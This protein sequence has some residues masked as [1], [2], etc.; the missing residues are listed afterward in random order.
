MGRFNKHV[1]IVG[2][3]RSG[4]SWLSET[5]ARQHRYR[6]L[7][8]PEQETRTRRGYL[9]CDQWI[10]NLED[11]PDAHRYLKQVFANGVNC[12]WIAQNSNRRFK[13]HL[14]PLIPKKYIIK[15]VRANLLAA[16]MN[17]TFNIPVIHMVRNPYAVIQ[18]QLQV[19]FPWLTDMRHFSSQPKLVQL[20][21][22][23]I[24]LDITALSNF[25]KVELLALRW[26]IENV[27]P[28]EV[29]PHTKGQYEVVRYEDLF[30]DIDYFYS[31]CDRVH[32]KPIATIEED[33]SLPSSK[34]HS[35][36]TFLGKKTSLSYT[37][38]EDLEAIQA[39]LNTFRTQLYPTIYSKVPYL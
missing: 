37:N 25:S 36:S 33:Y 16:Y 7:F 29:L 15:F 34:T 28:L 8:E 14:W 39:I 18:S 1:I 22:D 6:M 38:T 19:D 17:T 27:I 9:L 21:Q 12:D 10:R 26:C 31:L 35:K 23:H 24:S 30:T 13:R 20:I 2:T 32:L 5:M 3:A 4:T 11:A